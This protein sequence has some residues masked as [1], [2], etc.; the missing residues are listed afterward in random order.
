MNMVVFEYKNKNKIY[1]G[2]FISALGAL[3]KD[4]KIGNFCIENSVTHIFK[5]SIAQ[6]PRLF[7]P[8]WFLN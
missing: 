1:I 8:I 6:V 4:T 5:R 2:N 7:Y 3:V